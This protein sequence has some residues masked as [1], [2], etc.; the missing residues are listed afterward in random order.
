MQMTKKIKL[1]YW[2]AKTFEVTHEELLELDRKARERTGSDDGTFLS[3]N[4][5]LN[6]AALD[7]LVAL[8]EEW[9]VREGDNEVADYFEKD[10]GG[11]R[12]ALEE[13]IEDL[14]TEDE[15]VPGDIFDDEEDDDA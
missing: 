3:E 2:I 6:Q 1:R 7:G 15:R 8:P 4:D 5:W 11:S 12:Q 10:W 9:D 13:Y 14:R